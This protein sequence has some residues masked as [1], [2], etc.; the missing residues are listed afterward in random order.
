MSVS[1]KNKVVTAAIEKPDLYNRVIE[2]IKECVEIM[3]KKMNCNLVLE[4]NEIAV[5]FKDSKKGG[6]VWPH[7]YGYR[8]FLN[9]VLVKENEN[10]YLKTVIPHE[11]CHLFQCFL[12]GEATKS[13]GR[14]WQKLMRIFGLE[15]IRCHDMDVQNARMKKNEREYKYIC[16]CQKHVLSSHSHREICL[17]RVKYHCKK[18]KGELVFL[19]D[20]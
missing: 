18:C 17:K 1:L 8:V 14:E 6:Y 3:N 9:W 4:K 12:Y 11:V 19:R 2:R 5:F 15:P 20:L 7:K 13:H 16:N 10:N